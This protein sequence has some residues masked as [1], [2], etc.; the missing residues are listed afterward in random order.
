[1]GGLK[2]A[3]AGKGGCGKT[4]IAGTMARILAREGRSVLAI[5]G[6]SGPNLALTLG[7][8]ADRVGELPTLTTGLLRHR[9]GQAELAR[10]FEDVRSSYATGARDGVEL[11]VMGRPERAG[12]GCLSELH[13]TVRALVAAAPGG[14]G[15]VCILDTDASAEGFSRGV[16]RHADA[17]LIVAEGYPS[18]LEAARRM[19]HLA[20]D[21]GVV[22]VA[23]VASK[24][25][26]QHQIGAVRRLA[27]DVGVR[28]GGVVPY[29]ASFADAERAVQAPLDYAPHGPASAAIA[30]LARVC[31]TVTETGR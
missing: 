21:L 28:L 30:E 8:S 17:I 12:A 1:M 5:D 20:R 29:D 9:D 22:D 24:V 16:A 2:L 15:H 11:I 23:L 19:V 18:S 10:P 6:D 27:D 26:D 13:A 31:V 14:G 7:M 25:R 3:I 4:S